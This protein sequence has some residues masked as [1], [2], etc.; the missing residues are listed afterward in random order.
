MK[1]VKHKV[2]SIEYTKANGEK[3]KRD[4][5]PTFVPGNVKALDV[6]DMDVDN[7]ELLL[8]RLEDYNKYTQEI[9]ASMMTFESWLEATHSKKPIDGIKWRTF[10]A[11]NISEP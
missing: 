10:I 8:S 7:K 3:S 4:I 5:I 6:S 9:M 11:E 2:A 1:L